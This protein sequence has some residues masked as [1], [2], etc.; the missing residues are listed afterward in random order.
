MWSEAGNSL[1]FCNIKLASDVMSTGT[2][3][4][5]T[6]SIISFIRYKAFWRIG[7]ILL[8]CS[9]L[10]TKVVHTKHC[11]HQLSVCES[12]LLQIQNLIV[13]VT[14]LSFKFSWKE[15]DR[16]RTRNGTQAEAPQ[17]VDKDSFEYIF[18]TKWSVVHYN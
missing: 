7:H 8:Y 1:N 14:Q 4:R 9:N 6:N 13:S 16:K 2:G 5:K 15:K 17:R 12:H 3:K 18:P 10:C 11:T